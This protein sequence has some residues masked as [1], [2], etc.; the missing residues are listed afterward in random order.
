MNSRKQKPLIL[1]IC[2]ALIAGAF[3]FSAPG[4]HVEHQRCSTEIAGSIGHSHGVE[5]RSKSK[6]ALGDDAC[7]RTL[8]AVCVVVGL[9]SGASLL[10]S[11]LPAQSPDLQEHL[12]GIVP[13]PAFKPP[14]PAV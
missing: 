12:T 3:I 13:P 14:Q 9:C 1:R 7:C 8:C 2:V 5:H 6:A 10:V 4:F 11:V